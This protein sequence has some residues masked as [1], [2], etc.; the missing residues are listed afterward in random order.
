MLVASAMLIATSGKALA[1]RADQSGGA[2]SSTAAVLENIQRE[3]KQIE[4]LKAALESPDQSV[5]VSAFS[6]M[7]E[8][9]NPALV[10]LA[11][12]TAFA[13]ADQATKALAIRAAF[14]SV[15][16]MEVALSEPHAASEQMQQDLVTVRRGNSATV[17]D[18]KYDQNTGKFTGYFSSGHV[19]G[20]NISFITRSCTGS[21]NNEEG[22]WNFQGKV[23]CGSS[24][25]DGT[26]KL[27]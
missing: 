5:R 2:A 27:R 9:G 14:A 1:Q 17:R 10:E 4:Q 22:S 16:V 6:A 3:A 23:R 19:S 15:Q 13:S 7:V 11:I 21:L 8:S 12:T 26:F 25:F 24:V 18:I 20:T